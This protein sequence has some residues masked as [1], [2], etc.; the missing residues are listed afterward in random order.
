[1]A[2]W[3]PGGVP[4]GIFIARGP[5]P[6][7]GTD[8]VTCTFTSSSGYAKTLIVLGVPAAMYAA[9]WPGVPGAGGPLTYDTFYPAETS[10]LTGGATFF[11]SLNPAVGVARS[12]RPALCFAA[13][14]N[15]SPG[16]PPSFGQDWTPVASSASNGG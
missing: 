14:A 8:Q 16:G 5:A 9:G 12:G 10:R 13:F 15:L 4:S 1:M 2:A 6:L 11:A 3:Q 7:R